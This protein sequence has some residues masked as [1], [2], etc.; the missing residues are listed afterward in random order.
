MGI[1][2]DPPRLAV[3]GWA[4][5]GKQIQFGQCGHVDD[6]CDAAI[7]KDGCAHQPFDLVQIFLQALDD[8]LLLSE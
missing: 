1:A 3:L 8:H 4:P 5:H 6:G 2:E 7:A